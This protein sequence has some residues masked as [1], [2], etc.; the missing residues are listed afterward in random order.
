MDPTLMFRL[1]FTDDAGNWKNSRVGLQGGRAL[2]IQLEGKGKGDVVNVDITYCQL[3][4]VRPGIYGFLPVIGQRGSYERPKLLIISLGKQ[5][6]YNE[7]PGLIR[8]NLIR[9][10]A[11]LDKFPEVPSIGP[12]TSLTKKEAWLLYHNGGLPGIGVVARD[13]VRQLIQYLINQQ[14]AAGVPVA[15]AQA[16][17][18]KPAATA[19][20]PAKPQPEPKPALMREEPKQRVVRIE[21]AAET[22]TFG[23]QPTFWV[24][25]RKYNP[26][27][28]VRVGSTT[29]IT[30]KGGEA[31]HCTL[32]APGFTEGSQ[33]W[34]PESNGTIFR[35]RY[36]T[37][38]I[39]HLAVRA[40]RDGVWGSAKTL[41]IKVK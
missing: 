12:F 37:G 7:D 2:P 35:A 39:L 19:Q 41:K 13:Q 3:G 25:N 14:V 18:E 21:P 16:A 26:E 28:R 38:T 20:A 29:D 15:V 32:S 30:F 9:P 5:S 33:S 17:Q 22:K 27:V 23:P 1:S 4:A 11:E 24:A 40:Y 36:P 31:Y 6:I 8:F 34:S 10:L